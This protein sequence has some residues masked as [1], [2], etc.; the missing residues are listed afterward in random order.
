VALSYAE[1]A[2]ND[3]DADS[4]YTP[5]PVTESVELVASQTVRSASLPVWKLLSLAPG[6]EG[7]QS[8]LHAALAGDWGSHA[9]SGSDDIGQHAPHPTLFDVLPHELDSIL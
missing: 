7:A 6:S 9:V 3:G 4:V 2:A 1:A 8:V 5:R